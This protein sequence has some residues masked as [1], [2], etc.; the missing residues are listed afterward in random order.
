MNEFR[1]NSCLKLFNLHTIDIPGRCDRKDVAKAA[2][3]TSQ[4]VCL[5][6][7]RQEARTTAKVLISRAIP[8]T[9]TSPLDLPKAFR[10]LSSPPAG[11]SQIWQLP[12][13]QEIFPCF[14]PDAH[15][16]SM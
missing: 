10:W 11:P 12:K 1:G 16:G 2:A 3:I 15:H 5:V 14:F 8:L 6:Q 9:A 13:S 7:R 4:I